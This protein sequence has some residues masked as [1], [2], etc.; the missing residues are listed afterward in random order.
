MIIKHGFVGTF[1]FG[2]LHEV[3]KGLWFF[4]LHCAFWMLIGWANKLRSRGQNTSPMRCQ[5][6]SQFHKARSV[7][8]D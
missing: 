8:L 6:S 1:F 4:F 7:R 2:E 3:R 5:M